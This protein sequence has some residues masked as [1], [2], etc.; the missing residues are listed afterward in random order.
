MSNSE[1]TNALF[2]SW[3]SEDARLPEHLRPEEISKRWNDL[4]PDERQQVV[5]LQQIERSKI[6]QGENIQGYPAQSA[7]SIGR[8]KGCVN[9]KKYLSAFSPS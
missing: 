1:L 8:Y 3:I 2:Q 7:Q 4:S 9:N 6:R 5:M